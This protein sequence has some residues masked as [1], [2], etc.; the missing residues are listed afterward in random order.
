MKKGHIVL[1]VI[2]AM[3]LI[4]AALIIFTGQDKIE[5][6]QSTLRKSQQDLF[7]YGNHLTEAVNA[8]E[9]LEKQNQ[10]LIAFIGDIEV[11]ENR[12]PIGFKVN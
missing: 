10:K 1:I 4:F 9:Q 7:K 3:V 12:E 6:L 2:V 11:Q 5:K 8:R